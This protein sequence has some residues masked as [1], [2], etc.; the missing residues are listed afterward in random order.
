MNTP[1]FSRAQ[2]QSSEVLSQL[3]ASDP[4]PTSLASIPQANTCIRCKSRYENQY[5][6]WC[7]ACEIPIIQQNFQ[8]WSS[9]D[10]HLDR[11]IRETQLNCF[12]PL[13]NS[14]GELGGLQPPLRL[15]PYTEYSDVSLIGEGGF[16]RVYR[17]TW[18]QN[19]LY[20]TLKWWVGEMEKQNF[21]K[22]YKIIYEEASDSVKQHGVG[23]GKNFGE[24]G[25][26]K[27]FMNK[28]STR[29]G[30][31]RGNSKSGD[32]AIWCD[33]VVV[34]VMDEVAQKRLTVPDKQYT[35][36]IPQ[37]V[38]LKKLI[39][40]Q[41]I[42]CSELVR[43]LQTYYRCMNLGRIPQ[44]YGISREPET[45]DI[46]IVT[47]Y[48]PGGN[49]R[50]H[51]KE[52]YENMNWRRKVAIIFDVAKSLKT[53]HSYGF[54]HR[55]LHSGNVLIDVDPHDPTTTPQER[56]ERCSKMSSTFRHE[57]LISDLGISTP[58]MEFSNPYQKKRYGILPY[59]A[60]EVLQGGEY[61]RP[62]D[63]YGFAIVMW[64]LSSGELPY[65]SIP[66]DKKLAEEICDG[67]RP[68]I[69]RDTPK[70]YANLMERCWDSSAAKRP[71]IDEI[72][73]TIGNWRKPLVTDSGLF[74]KAEEIRRLILEE[75]V[76]G[77]KNVHEGAVYLSKPLSFGKI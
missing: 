25:S 56:Q 19:I 5:N 34:R 13:H 10:E 55:N 42:S 35:G 73:K 63:V 24:S 9:E 4:L 40:S 32:L 16:S 20:G 1:I 50:H 2:K 23:M 33:R 14:I 28:V 7:D 65:Q 66:H 61:S 68:E 38:A 41:S 67:K 71:G 37:H 47:Q 31:M 74:D 36:T 64:E 54:V 69:T 15:I 76:V 51:I 46:V 12:K 6:H 60:P 62:S 75:N 26:K 52:N 53:I 39:N 70:F 27:G 3:P 57:T 18:N 43:E 29:L 72:V 17:A 58:A 21:D 77:R 45:K 22:I 8:D 59:M 48:A 49:L 44:L 30:H 11:F